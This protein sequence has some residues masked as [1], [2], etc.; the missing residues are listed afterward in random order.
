VQRFPAHLDPSVEVFEMDTD[1][2]DPAFAETTAH[3]LDE[4][5]RTSAADHHG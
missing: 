4:R 1:I 2:N 3:R 5:Y